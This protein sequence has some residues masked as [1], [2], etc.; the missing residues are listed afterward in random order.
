MRE[1][2]V[3]WG[4]H[5]EPVVWD[6]TGPQQEAEALLLRTPW[7]YHQKVDLFREW[8]TRTEIPMW[9]PRELV[10]WNAH[11]SYLLE[12]ADRGV[13]TVPTRIFDSMPPES[14]AADCGWSDVVVKPA[15]SASAD[16]TFRMKA[17]ELPR[18]RG[19]FDSVRSR[20]EVLIQPFLPEIQEEGEIS[21]VAFHDPGGPSILSHAVRKR[22][23]SGD[24]RVQVRGRVERHEPSRDEREA[25]LGVLERIPGE[26][27]YARVDMVPT[28]A[29]LVLMELELIE[30][31]LFFDRAPDSA[32]I[33]CHAL[34]RRLGCQPG[35]RPPRNAAVSRPR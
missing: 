1:I 12:L 17:E 29:G 4:F 31:E 35:G 30:P 24:Y 13:P 33:L 14:F 15:V 23:G 19:I 16:L 18:S 34:A 32:E 22:P 5:V 10:L 7:D 8:L 20:S 6:Q 21:F 9:N 11:K 26:W 2:L 28:R 3:G 27:L 25:V